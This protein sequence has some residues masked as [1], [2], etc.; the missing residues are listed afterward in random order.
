M[1]R[2]LSLLLILLSIT[3]L[4]V[5]YQNAGRLS[6][7][8]TPKTLR[9]PRYFASI[10]ESEKR[11]NGQQKSPESLLQNSPFL[12]S[13]NNRIDGEKPDTKCD[14]KNSDVICPQK[15]ENR[16]V[17]EQPMSLALDP[18]RT[19]ATIQMSETLKGELK[20]SS[21]QSG[22]T[23]LINKR[24]SDTSQLN[25]QMDQGLGGSNSKVSI[26]IKW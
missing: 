25:F 15:S 2:H 12:K 7:N 9:F 6:P 11:E 26:D 19:L 22:A 24:L 1:R 13:L 10:Y 23:L 21:P 16:P 17:K 14:P 20:Y 5:F 8:E 3:T 4:F 18:F